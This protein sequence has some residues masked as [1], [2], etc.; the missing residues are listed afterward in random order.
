MALHDA[1]QVYRVS[2]GPEFRASIIPL[3]N[4]LLQATAGENCAIIR[5]FAG[6]F[7]NGILYVM[8]ICSIVLSIL[9]EK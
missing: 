7:F 9:P 2:H 1:Y 5:A 6:V 3:M 8:K 4:N